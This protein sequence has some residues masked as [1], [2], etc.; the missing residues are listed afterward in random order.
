MMEARFARSLIK[1]VEDTLLLCS[2]GL[3]LLADRAE[4]VIRPFKTLLHS[5]VEYLEALDQVQHLCESAVVHGNGW[6]VSEGR[7]Y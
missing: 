3:K 6:N 4:S 2:N 7:T 1:A 5:P